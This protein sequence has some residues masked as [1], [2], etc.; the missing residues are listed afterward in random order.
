MQVEPYDAR[1]TLYTL[2]QAHRT[3]EQHSGPIHITLFEEEPEGLARHLLLLSVL[4][5]DSL[6]ATDRI[7]TLLE[8]H[9]NVLLRQKTAEYLGEHTRT[10]PHALSRKYTPDSQQSIESPD[11]PAVRLCPRSP[12]ITAPDP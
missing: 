3:L 2:C 10:L 8:L 5:D 1:H 9:G 6:P 12:Q 7:Q 4:L 11:G